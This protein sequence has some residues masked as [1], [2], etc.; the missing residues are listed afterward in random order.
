MGRGND[1]LDSQLGLA[2]VAIAQQS[3]GTSAGVIE[4]VVVTTRKRSENLQEIPDSV[5]VFGETAIERGII[6]HEPGQRPVH[7]VQ[8]GNWLGERYFDLENLM[9][10]DN[11]AYLNLSLGVEADAWMIQLRGTNLADR[12][13]PEDAF[14]GIASTLARFKNTPRQVLAE[15]TCRFQ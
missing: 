1:S 11:A 14:Y 15:F 5:T 10:D 6:Q 4:E 2:S 7:A 9:G 8:S 12:L 13:E 3:A